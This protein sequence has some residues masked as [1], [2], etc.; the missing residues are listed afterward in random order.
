MAAPTLTSS[1]APSTLTQ[2][3]I[4]LVYS[5]LICGMFLAS[6]DQ[7]IVST[8]LPTI[9]GD[10]GGATHITW[11]VTAYLLTSTI[12]TPLW[13]K[14]GDLYGRKFFFQLAIVIFL[15]GSVV[16]AVAGS[17]NVLI[18]ARGLQG[19]GAGGLLVG[20]QAIIG[21]IVAPKDRGRYV[22]AFGAMFGVATVGGP[23]LG[24]YLT[25]GPGWQWIFWINIPIGL[26]ALAVTAFVLPNFRRRVEHVVDYL[27]ITLL[28]LGVGSLVIYASLGGVTFPWGSPEAWAFL[29]VGIVGSVGFVVAE[30]RAVEPVLPM[31]LFHNKTFSMI[32]I[33]GFLVGFAM[34]GAMTFFPVFLQDVQGVSTTASGLHLL[35]MMVGMFSTSILSGQLIARGSS[36]HKYPIIGTALMV[37]GLICFHFVTV[38]TSTIT[39]SIWMFIFGV[40]MGCVMQ[41]LVIAVQN[42]VAYSDLGVATSGSTFFRSIGGTFG[43]AVFGA[44]YENVYPGHLE[45]ALHGAPV[46]PGFNPAVLTP[47]LIAELPDDIRAAVAQATAHSTATVFTWT[48][49]IA[50]IAF[51]ISWFVPRGELS[52]RVRSFDQHDLEVLDLA[53]GDF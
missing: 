47:K 53:P 52:D 9:V 3:Q 41:V 14:F 46:P 10:L 35:P 24:G 21:D 13:G 32:A 25:D 12:S 29:T 15:L 8:A 7:T 40:G 33:L 37:V 50:V 39:L 11:I 49:P 16:S 23:L 6:L 2:R 44:I 4:W 1:P 27:G 17:M 22:G 20:A 31:R 30:H 19:M 26:I 38:S 5:G 36:Y 48:I 34:F 28:A 42:A 18:A 45:A 43:A 51:A